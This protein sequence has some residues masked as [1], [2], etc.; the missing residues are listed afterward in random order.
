[1]ADKLSPTMTV[2]EFANGYWYLDELKKFARL[3]RD[4]DAV[5]TGSYVPEGILAGDW[6]TATAKGISAFYDIDTPVTLRTMQ[7]RECEYLNRKLLRKF[8]VYFS[9]TGGPVLDQLRELGAARPVALYCSVDPEFHAPLDVPKEWM[10]GYLGTYAADRQPALEAMLFEV[11]EEMPERKFAVAGPQYPDT[12]TW[13]EN[14]EHIPHLSPDDHPAFYCAQHFTLNLTRGDMRA[15]GY[16]PSVRLFE[17][18]ACGVPIISDR[19]PGLDTVFAPDREILLADSA[20]EVMRHLRTVRAPQRDSVAAAARAR[21]LMS[22]TAD[23]RAAEL[24][25]ALQSAARRMA[26]TA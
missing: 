16:S 2:Q 12:T 25:L 26:R 15:L 17:A 14:V 8:D 1:M 7:R 21:V 22:H 6:I 23:H 11:A 9:F 24:E 13:P 20:A 19:W 18:A 10:L 5:I 3:V 4:A